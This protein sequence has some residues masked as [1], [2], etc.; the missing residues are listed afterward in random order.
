[1]LPP[2]SLSRY[3]GSL[4]SHPWNPRVWHRDI[5]NSRRA[6]KDDWAKHDEYENIEQKVDMLHNSV[7]GIL[8][9]TINLIFQEKK[10]TSNLVFL[11][12][13]QMPRAKSLSS[14]TTD[15]GEFSFLKCTILLIP[16]PIWVR[17]MAIKMQKVTL[18]EVFHHTAKGKFIEK[19][20]DM[21]DRFAEL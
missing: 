4:I 2:W 21:F 8:A 14:K 15:L 11:S 16:V 18:L 20:A 6:R 3:H 17:F 1:M 13:N 7:N 19:F 5:T 10:E 9:K 12:F